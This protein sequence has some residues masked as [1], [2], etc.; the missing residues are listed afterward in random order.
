MFWNKFNQRGYSIGVGL[1]L[2][3][4]V[5]LAALAVAT[6]S[7][8]HCD[9]EAGP[10]AIAARQALDTGQVKY[11]LAY[12]QPGAEAELTAAFKQARDVRKQGGAARDLAERYFVETAIRLHRA[13]E[14]AAYTGVTDEPVPP[15]ILA[16]D[17]AMQTGQLKEVNALLNEAVQHG[18]QE[19]YEAVVAAR[20]QAAK[21]NTVAAQRERAEAE[22][23]FEKY[24]YE[25]YTAAS[26]AQPH[27]EGAPAE[28]GHTH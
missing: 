8:A 17:K 6:P 18:L 10:V 16:A 9:S 25:L 20:A 2:V 19:K 5:I 15:A 27:A 26:A 11:I 13:G 3:A 23:I 28:G 14:G 7:Q 21:L 1:V 22:L 24:V 4:A 12:V